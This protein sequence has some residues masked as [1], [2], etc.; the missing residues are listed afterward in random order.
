MGIR[1]PVYAAAYGIVNYSY[2]MSDIDYI[3]NSAIY[4]DEVV[5]KKVQP[6]PVN[7]EN[8][9]NLKRTISSRE[10]ESKEAYNSN[11]LTG[12]ETAPEKERENNQSRTGSL[13]NFFKKFFD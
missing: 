13:K 2:K 3:V 8:T 7:H 1:N 6:E 11:K 10:T 9:K 5:A 12:E 4:G